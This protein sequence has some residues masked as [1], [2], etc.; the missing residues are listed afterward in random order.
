MFSQERSRSGARRTRAVL[1]AGAALATFALASA[2][3]AQPLVHRF[4]NPNFGGNP[5]NTDLLAVANIDRPA[6]PST[7]AATPTAD[8]LLASQLRSQLTSTL[9]SNILTTILNARPGD[10]GNFVLGDQ[11]ITYVRTATETTVTFLNTRTG[12][13]SQLIIPASSGSASAQAAAPSASASAEQ[14]LGA[15]GASRA[16]SPNAGANNQPLLSAPPL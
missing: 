9:S 5:F 16:G 2:A 11:K 1:A 3:C 15:M 10:S 13:S 14:A 12:E 7:S 6:A 4:I 8:E